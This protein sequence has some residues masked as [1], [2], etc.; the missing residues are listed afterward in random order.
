MKTIITYVKEFIREQWNPTYF[1]M[2]GGLLGMMFFV[3][4]E[5]GL[6]SS[7]VR[8]LSFPT[9]QTVFYFVFY[10]VP[11][12]LTHCAYALVKREAGVLRSPQFWL[13]SLFGFVVLSVYIAL[14]NGPWY[15]LRT[16]PSLFEGVARE[17][18][19][20]VAR[21]ASNILPFALMV[22]PLIGY[23]WKVDRSA[24]PLYGF[25]AKTINLQSYFLILFF[26]I[27]LIVAVSF[28]S[29]F[30]HAYPRYKFGFPEHLGTTER[31]GFV[32]VFQLCYGAD[33]VFVEFFFR[34]FMVLA[35]A[36]LLGTRAIIPMVVV[37][38][39]IHFEK[40][41]LEALSSI[42][43]GLVLGVISSRTKSIYGG[44]ILHLGIAYMM[45]VAGALHM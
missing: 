29:D 44:V 35:F 45:E 34:G 40:P 23:W 19:P 16:Q 37:Y 25:S 42:V 27:P 11:Y 1:L 20:F 9:G 30:Q 32:G 26:L 39:L 36:R 5:Y 18:Q 15:I 43:G 38:A 2:V 24:M 41:L 28:T 12:V 13:L 3:N 4:Y 7:I 10:F 21:C 17:F 33:F 8:R 31:G 22:I 6:E 14:H